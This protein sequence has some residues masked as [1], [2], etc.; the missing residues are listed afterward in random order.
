M[1]LLTDTS[2]FTNNRPTTFFGGKNEA[3]LGSVP[4]RPSTRQKLA[5]AIEDV[6]KK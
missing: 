4:S 2:G 3:I 6:F 5:F 1:P